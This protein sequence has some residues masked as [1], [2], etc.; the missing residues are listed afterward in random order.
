VT[1]SQIEATLGR[2]RWIVPG[3]AGVIGAAIMTATLGLALVDPTNIEWLMHHDYRLHHLGWHLYRYGPWTFPLGASPLLIWPIGSSIGLTDSMPIVAIWL[4]AL[5]PLLPTDFQFI[6]LWL[7]LSFALQGVFGALLMR[8]ATL[9]PELQLLGATLLILSPPLIFRILHAA[10]TAHWLILAALWLSLKEDAAQPT[11]RNCVAWAL[12]LA[13]SA[14]TQPYIM[15]MIAVLFA[16]A[17]LRQLIAAPRRVLRVAMNGAIALGAA[18]LSLWQSGS[19]M[20]RSDEGL[21]VGGFGSWSTNLLAFIMPTEGRSF[22]WRGPIFYAHPG[23]YEGYAYLGAGLLLLAVVAIVARPFARRPVAWARL[24]QYIPLMLALVFLEVMALGQN[25]SWGSQT[26]FRYDVDWWGPLIIFRTHGR[27]VW[28]LYYATAIAILFAISR[29]RYRAAL[30]LC[31][32]GV[33]VQTVDVAGMTRYVRDTHAWG[34]RNPL[35]SGFWSQVPQ[36]YKQLVLVPSNLCVGGGY[37]DDAAFA[38]LAG[39]YGLGINSGMTARYDVQ[40]AR[41]YC[42]QLDLEIGSGRP[43]PGSLY[44]VRADR[45]AGVRPP[46]TGD[47]ARCTMIDGFGVCFT[48]NSYSEWKDDFDVVRSRLPSREEFSQFYTELDDVYRTALGRGLRQAPGATETRVESLARYLAY[49]IEGCGH[50]E[51]ETKTL[52]NLEG[53]DDRS[54]CDRLALRVEMPPADQT[55]AFARRLDAVLSGKPGVVTTTTHIDLEG[56]AVWIQEY[57]RERARG[58][59]PQDARAAVVAAIRGSGQ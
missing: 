1:R 56:E 42:H 36:H 52:R 50:E 38:L 47:D 54:L 48:A 20:V 28:P 9:R 53:Q 3:L 10:L 30:A 5:S 58:I 14:A 46:Q 51:A 18:T 29:M 26:I 19:L 32:L 44:I 13:A 25:V 57:A 8:L 35:Q 41:A 59:R 4:K 45:L 34:F 12:L 37:I 55:L 24:R 15:F 11:T 27:M 2:R 6:G 39:R 43:Q 40:K 7:V 22:F 16:A 33:I 23:Q 17:L 21:E 31:A 49:R